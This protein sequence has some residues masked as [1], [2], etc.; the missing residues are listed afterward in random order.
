MRRGRSRFNKRG[1]R[2]NEAAGTGV[3]MEHGA[4]WL[5]LATRLRLMSLTSSSWTS[6]LSKCQARAKPRRWR[7]YPVENR[8]LAAVARSVSG[9][10]PP[11]A[12]GAPRSSADCI[13]GRAFGNRSKWLACV[14]EGRVKSH[15]RPWVTRADAGARPPYDRSRSAGLT[16][17]RWLAKKGAAGA[18]RRNRE[19]ASGP[20]AW[21]P[22]TWRASRGGVLGLGVFSEA[23]VL[24]REQAGRYR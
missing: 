24:R 8:P 23:L 13:A 4:D 15:S 22:A 7:G 19:T 5:R 20:T 9:A 18:M 1:R 3:G 16:A 21:T 11:A 6:G 17:G 2:A 10:D 14:R 12:L